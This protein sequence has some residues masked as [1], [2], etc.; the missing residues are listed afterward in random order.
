MVKQGGLSMVSFKVFFAEWEKRQ[1]EEERM[2]RLLQ[3]HPK[4]A[5]GKKPSGASK[6]L[7][8][9]EHNSSSSQSN[10]VKAESGRF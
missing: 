3:Q 9:H 10:D 2:K 4:S 1:K 5:L 7:D 8:R 6:P